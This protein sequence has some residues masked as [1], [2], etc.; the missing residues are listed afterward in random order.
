MFDM[1]MEVDGA[2]EPEDVASSLSHYLNLALHALNM[3]LPPANIG[4]T[5]LFAKLC[6][7]VSLR[8]VKVNMGKSIVPQKGLRQKQWA[9]VSRLIVLLQQDYMSRRGTQLKRLDVTVQSFKWSK[10]AQNQLEAI[11]ALYSPLR[12]AMARSY[13]PG[14]A[15]LLA[16]RDD[17]L[18]LIEKTSGASR[19]RFTACDLNKILIGTVPDRGGRAWELEPP[20][21]EM[22][23][24]KRRENMP[25][26]RGRGRGNSGC[27]R[28]PGRGAP[29][30]HDNY[31]QHGGLV[32]HTDPADQRPLEGQLRFNVSF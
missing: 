7:E 22:P 14:I 10:K 4:I 2:D 11:N 27:Y 18:L 25:P 12:E 32:F 9:Q 28:G 15:H 26:Q 21:P 23:S 31:Y 1:S 5:Q 17:P 24:F 19:R 13:P 29:Q 16:A 3:S 20:P 6:Q 30:H 8:K